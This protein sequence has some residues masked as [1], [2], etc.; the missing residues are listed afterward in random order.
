MAVMIAAAAVGLVMSVRMA[1]AFLVM[2]LRPDAHIAGL[3]I[4]LALVCRLNTAASR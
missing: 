1:V 3:G 4:T 2:A